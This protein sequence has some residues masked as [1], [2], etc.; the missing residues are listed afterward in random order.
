MS[1]LKQRV[2]FETDPNKDK[3]LFFKM[4]PAE[5]SKDNGFYSIDM[6]GDDEHLYI[7]SDH[8]HNYLLNTYQNECHETGVDPL[9]FNEWVEEVR[10]E[11]VVIDLIEFLET[12]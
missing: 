1:A 9:Q 7:S 8:V 5:L 2:L 4:F 10:L 6:H 12:A 3:R 11:S